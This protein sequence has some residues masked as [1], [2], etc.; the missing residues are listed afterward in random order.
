M[1]LTVTK[2]NVL[3]AASACPT[4]KAT[5]EKLFPEVFEQPKPNYPLKVGDVYVH[6]SGYINAFRLEQCCYSDPKSYQLFG[7]GCSVNSGGF[8]SRLHT[9]EEVAAYLAKNDMVYSHSVQDYTYGGRI[10]DL[11]KKV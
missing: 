2:E 1:N 7:L 4:A 9:L 8:F 11:Y 10:Y 5:L 6:P 3:K